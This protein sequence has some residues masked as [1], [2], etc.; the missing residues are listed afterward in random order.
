M[1]ENVGCTRWDDA[2]AGIA[3]HKPIGTF[4]YRAVSASGNDHLVPTQRR[5]PGEGFRMAGVQCFGKV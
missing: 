2:R 3:A 4:G 1:R 5:L